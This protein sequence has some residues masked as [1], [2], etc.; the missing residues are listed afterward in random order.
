MQPTWT[1]G[2]TLN[3]S[4]RNVLAPSF[5]LASM[6]APAFRLGAQA[7]PNRT[8]PASVDATGDTGWTL[9]GATTPTADEDAFTTAPA[10][11]AYAG[12][13][14]T[15][16]LTVP[17]S[18]GTGGAAV[19]G[20]IDWNRN[21]TFADGEGSITVGCSG[22]GSTTTVTWS[23]VTVA[24][25][26]L[27]ATTLRLAIGGAN[28]QVATATTA[29]LVGEVEDWQVTLTPALRVTKTADV[30]TMPA[31]GDVTFTV[32]VTNASSSSVTA[33]VV[34]DYTG[35]WDDATLGA[36]S[37][38]T[39]VTHQT[40][41]RRL[42]WQVTLAAGESRD[43]TYTMTTRSAAGGPGDQVMTN[44]VVVASQ[45]VGT[46]TPVTCVP[47]SAEAT[48]GTCAR[49]DLYRPALTVD[50][51]AYR[52]TDTTFTSPLADDVVLAPGTSVRWRYV[53]T[54]T[55]STVVEGVTL[56][57]AA[58]ETRTTAD[59]TATTTTAPLLTCPGL[60]P[61]TSVTLGTLAPG[62]VRTCTATGV[63][64]PDP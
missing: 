36:W 64:V 8:V 3:A 59:G 9:P 30:A 21:G 43:L 25:A 32:T 44:V 20:W 41:V 33:Y 18:A 54:N 40:A 53:V 45:A 17:C 5:T 51:Q 39:G 34:D 35:A 2:T 14:R 26:Q 50:K 22:Q 28:A 1:A 61:G 42:S 19:R 11:V 15:S 29:I 62:D 6:A 31:G 12:S 24:P 37:P 63:V 46:T 57:D 49:T 4:A 38:T 23:N 48:S 56:G 13:P 60:A 10:I 55:G 58:T 52:A 27:G 16:T 7:F 47:E